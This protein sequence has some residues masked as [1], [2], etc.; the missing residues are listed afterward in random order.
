MEPDT[1][2]LVDFAKMTDYEIVEKID[3]ETLRI[4]DKDILPVL[5]LLDKKKHYKVII[6]I[7]E[8]DLVS[9]M[10]LEKEDAVFI[11]AQAYFHEGRDNESL[12]YLNILPGGEGSRVEQY[13]RDLMHEMAKDNPDIKSRLDSQR[14]DQMKGMPQGVIGGRGA[15][16]AKK[17]P[18]I[19]PRNKPKNPISANK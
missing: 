12:A 13:R 9:P 11:A 3:D 10:E 2:P 17:T 14:L 19:L 1:I 6:R 15:G 8:S 18:V 5:A 16:P 4:S 7:V